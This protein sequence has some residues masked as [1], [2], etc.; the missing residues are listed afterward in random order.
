M[1]STAIIDPPDQSTADSIEADIAEGTR[2]YALK[3]YQ[4]ATEAFS[5]ACEKLAGH[6]GD[7]HPAL[8][9]AH[10]CY[11]KALVKNA[12]RLS[13]V[14]GDPQAENLTDPQL[15]VT[16]VAKTSGSSSSQYMFLGI[17]MGRVA[18]IDVIFGLKPAGPCKSTNQKPG[19]SK[20]SNT[21]HIHFSGDSSADDSEC[22]D[23]ESEGDYEQGTASCT[24]EEELEAAFQVLELARLI[25][26]AQ[27]AAGTTDSQQEEA[28]QAKVKNKLF[29]VFELL[30][31]VHQEAGQCRSLKVRV[32]PWLAVVADVSS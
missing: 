31:E 14:L 3:N 6:Y 29:Q 25:L 12:I 23:D 17:I 32:A 10:I 4:D 16:E 11:G 19:S 27:L 2:A 8:V 20:P 7:C 24:A 18:R 21:P 15:S 26:E 13:A 1:T 28:E 22:E 9:D 30:A 5:K